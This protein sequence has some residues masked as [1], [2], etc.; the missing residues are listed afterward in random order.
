MKK[1]LVAL[2]LGTALLS[3]AKIEETLSII[4]PDAV[5]EQHIGDII[6]IFE[7]NN[8]QVVAMRMTKLSKKEVE[9]FYSALKEKP[10]FPDLVSY[11]TSGPVVLQVLKGEDA[12]ARNR[13]IM[14]AT[15]PKKAAAGTIRALYGKSI[16]SNAVHGSDSE[17]NARKEIKFFFSE[18]QIYSEQS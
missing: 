17:E 5:K 16:D 6:S 14:G 8:L 7:K 18:S 15:D 12:I 9:E 13:Q 1:L 3:E 4:K 10:F 2:A 11:M